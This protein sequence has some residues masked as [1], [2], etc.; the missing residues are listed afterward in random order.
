MKRFG[1]IMNVIGEPVDEAGPDQDQAAAR[2]PPAGAG[3]RRAVDGCGNPVDRHQGRR[4]AGALRQGRQD[5]PV[6]RR[7][8]RQD[9]AHPG[10]DQQHRQDPWRLFGV[11]RRRRAH[12]RGQRPLSRVHRIGRQQEGRRQ[13]LEMRARLRPDERAAGSARPRR[14]LR[15]HGR[16]VFPR[17]GPGRA[18]LRR[19]HLPLHAGR[20]GSLGA[21]R[22]HSFRGGLSADARHRHGRAAGAHHHDA[23]RARSPRCRRSTCRP[24]T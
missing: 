5:R 15:P 6:R 20:L 2:H 12:P 3:I 11:R 4:S 10:A 9:R 23:P 21:S 8:R 1:R 24:T 22:P 7:R 13:G 17:P 19:Q 16:R 18:V 14:P